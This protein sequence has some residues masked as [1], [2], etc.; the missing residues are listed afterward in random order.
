[1]PSTLVHG[2]LPASCATYESPTRPRL[3]YFLVAAIIANLPDLDIALGVL[4]PHSF[5]SIH[6]NVGHNLFI[7]PFWIALG[8]WLLQRW[9]GVALSRARLWGNAA[10]LVA[11][12]L[13]L[14]AMTAPQPTGRGSVPLLWPL[15]D[16]GWQLP[17]PLFS[18]LPPQFRYANPLADRVLSRQFWVHTVFQEL[19]WVAAFFALWVAV[20]HLIAFV[21]GKKKRTEPGFADATPGQAPPI[22]RIS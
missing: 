17:L 12:H 22:S 10:A 5:N 15:S 7:L 16:W 8:A 6:R 21:S 11:S 4:F 3:R 1:M 20:R 13:V 18:G 19:F 14:D 2:L 9:G